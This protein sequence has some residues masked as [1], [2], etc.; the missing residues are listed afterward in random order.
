MK[1]FEEYVEQKNLQLSKKIELMNKNNNNNLNENEKEE[2]EY[3]K[4][5]V[6]KLKD[7][8]YTKENKNKKI[9]EKF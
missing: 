7:D 5:E 2:F 8:L 4:Q 6:Q 1:N 9:S 3:L